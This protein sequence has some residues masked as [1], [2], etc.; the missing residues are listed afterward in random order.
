M[1]AVLAQPA[2]ATSLDRLAGDYVLLR[3]SHTNKGL[4]RE[5]W[6]LAACGVATDKKQGLGRWRAYN[7]NGHDLI[8][9]ETD[10]SETEPNPGRALI[11]MP[12]A[13]TDTL[14]GLRVN[15]GN[16]RVYA[17]FAT[18]ST[19]KLDLIAQVMSNN[20]I[21]QEPLSLTDEAVLA[22]AVGQYDLNELEYFIRKTLKILLQPRPVMFSIKPLPNSGR[23]QAEADAL[24]T[25]IMA[26]VKERLAREGF[27]AVCEPHQSIDS[28]RKITSASTDDSV[29]L[30]E[31]FGLVETELTAFGSGISYANE[32]LSQNDGESSAIVSETLQSPK[33]KRE[34]KKRPNLMHERFRN[35]SRI[36]WDQRKDRR[37]ELGLSEHTLEDVLTFIDKVY[38]DRRELKLCQADLKWDMPLYNRLN[39][40]L[41]T[42]S[43]PAKFDLPSKKD[44]NLSLIEKTSAAGGSSLRNLEVRRQMSSLVT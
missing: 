31:V 30:Q 6:R 11:L 1:E 18:Q 9:A 32:S 13:P 7:L 15:R 25:K 14:F 44:L 29:G 40:F 21:F 36:R 39:T 38:N 26:D 27:E 4:R 23:T 41:R 37:A 19:G 42:N 24:H 22:F 43:L 17:A 10:C 8:T 2:E 33:P 35:E 20:P 16:N 28:E 3:G 12:G 34:G 5:C